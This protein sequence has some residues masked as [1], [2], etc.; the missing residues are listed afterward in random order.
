[1]HAR[2]AARHTHRRTYNAHVTTPHPTQLASSPC[3]ARIA[4]DSEPCPNAGTSCL[5]VQRRYSSRED[6]ASLKAVASPRQPQRPR[7]WTPAS[8]LLARA[9]RLQLQRQQGSPPRP[10][11]VGQLLP[12]QGPPAG[13]GR[14][15]RLVHNLWHGQGPLLIAVA[16]LIFSCQS[17]CI[18]LLG[19]RIP[20]YQVGLR[21]QGLRC[22]E[23][24]GWGGGVPMLRQVQARCVILLGCVQVL[25]HLL[26]RH[27]CSTCT[28]TCL[29][30]SAHLLHTV[31]LLHG[32]VGEPHDS[33]RKR[34]DARSARS[35]EGGSPPPRSTLLPYSRALPPTLTTLHLL[36]PLTH[37]P[38]HTQAGPYVLCTPPPTP[39][40]QTKPPLP[41]QPML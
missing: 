31:G 24:S 5:A 36:Y 37:I 18:K 38:T 16:A 40:R 12:Q 33:S 8:T 19:G 3:Q 21:R 14:L 27:A 23:F 34:G 15:G 39:T 13:T 1:M 2:E 22:A 7:C 20:T 6:D 17:L 10:G 28:C 26:T 4:V 41:P 35:G 9:R 29:H 30:L 11:M 32:G 25:R